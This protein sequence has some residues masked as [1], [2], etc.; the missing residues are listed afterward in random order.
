[1]QDIASIVEPAAKVTT[2]CGLE[3]RKSEIFV[4]FLKSKLKNVKKKIIKKKS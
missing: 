2:V 1:M 3:G 4:T